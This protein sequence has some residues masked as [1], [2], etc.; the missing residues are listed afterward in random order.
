M[1]IDQY[2]LVDRFG[3]ACNDAVASL[4]VGAGLSM[5]AGLPGWEGLLTELAERADVPTSL[6]D[7][8]L[9]ADY[10][11]H[12][13]SVGRG[14]LEH[15]LLAQLHGVG[16]P[17]E[18]HR[19]VAELPVREVWTTNYDRLLELAM[20]DAHTV[21][22]DDD[23][24]LADSSGR[25]VIKMHGSLPVSRGRPWPARPVITR[26]DYERYPTDHP[27]T[28]TRLRATYL[29][30]TMLFLGFSFTDPNIEVL[31][32][33]A[34]LAGTASKD[35]H[36]TV[37]RRPTDEGERRLH[38]LR[39]ADLERSGIAVHEIDD[40]NQLAPLLRA[41]IRR[42]QPPRCFVAGSGD[43][44]EPWCKAMADKIAPHRDWQLV[45]LGGPA[46]WRTTRRV[47]ALRRAEG[48]YAPEDLLLYFRQLSNASA[49]PLDDRAGTAIYSDLERE[50]LVTSVL[51]Q[52]R[53]MLVLGGSERTTEEVAWARERGLG[54]VPVAAS[55]GAARAAWEDQDPGALLGG[56]PV[57]QRSWDQL[58]DDD[59]GIATAAAMRLLEQAMYRT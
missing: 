55:G 19:L 47:A 4:F 8:P 42:S 38:D 58:A 29:T 6:A 50:P 5:D 52:C 28:W 56:R 14:A 32:R 33:L 23:A 53:A 24:Q 27:R 40:F 36:L 18:G 41:I 17:T 13:P 37:L 10:I 25:S 31:L 30:T 22:R 12:E 59:A 48:T 26:G 21:T 34:R 15:H 1:P 49:P 44:L 35:R 43:N 11:E 54:V 7:L 45:S 16:E 51:D 46:G 9:V 39:V 3:Q 2:E 57:D 20:P